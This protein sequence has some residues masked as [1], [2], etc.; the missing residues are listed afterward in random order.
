[1]IDDTIVYTVGHQGIEDGMNKEC[2]KFSEYTTSLI[3]SNI[4]TTEYYGDR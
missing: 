4:I 1:M 2:H 3:V